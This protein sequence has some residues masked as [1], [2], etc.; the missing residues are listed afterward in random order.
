MKE[1]H[2]SNLVGSIMRSKGVAE[3]AAF[4]VSLRTSMDSLYSADRLFGD[5]ISRVAFLLQGKG[6]RELN[7]EI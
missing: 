3:R 2:T 6:M 1:S 4:G 7:T 5:V